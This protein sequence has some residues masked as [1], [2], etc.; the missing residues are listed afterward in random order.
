MLSI[1]MYKQKKRILLCQGIYPVAYWFFNFIKIWMIHAFS[2]SFLVY[3]FVT[4]DTMRNWWIMFEESKGK[5]CRKWS[6]QYES[7]GMLLYM[8]E[9]KHFGFPYLLELRLLIYLFFHLLLPPTCRVHNKVLHIDWQIFNESTW[10]GLQGSIFF[11]WKCSAMMKANM[12]WNKIW[13]R[14]KRI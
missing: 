5:K 13:I 14:M 8:A 6:A 11:M 10:F 7:Y 1:H 3:Y 4:T 12:K 9:W 2:V